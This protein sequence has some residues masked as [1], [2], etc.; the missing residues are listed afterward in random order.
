MKRFERFAASQ[1][2][3]IITI[4]LLFLN[5]D[6]LRASSGALVIIGGTLIIAIMINLGIWFGEGIARAFDDDIYENLSA[7]APQAD[8]EADNMEKRKRERIDT[9]LRDLSSDDLQSLRQRLQDGNIDDDLLY[10]HMVGDD[11]ELIRRN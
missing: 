1:V 7:D 10:D 9:V 4:T 6:F 2:I 5:L 8:T 11:G 3:W